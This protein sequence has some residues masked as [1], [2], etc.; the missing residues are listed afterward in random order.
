MLVTSDH[1]ISFHGGDNRRAPTET[2]LAELAFTPLFIKFPGETEGKVVEKHVTI[3]D[4]LPTVADGIGIKVPWSIEGRSAL[5]DS[6]PSD[7]VRVVNVI[8]PYDEALAQRD[9]DLAKQIDLFGTGPFD[10]AFFGLGPYEG[11]LGK[12]LPTLDTAPGKAGAATVDKAGSRLVRDFPEGGR[13][14]PSPLEATLADVSEGADLALAVNGT[15]A[16]RAQAY[17][18][19]T[20]RG[21]RVVPRPR[22]CVRGRR[23]RGAG[24]Q[25]ERPGLDADAAG[26]RDLADRNLGA[27]EQLFAQAVQA[28]AHAAVQAERARLQDEAADQLGVDAARRLDLAAR[29]VLDRASRSSPPRRRRARPRSS[30]RPR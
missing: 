4:I 14:V 23:E 22:G 13:F 17:Q 3:A 2:N 20:G 11:L 26:D 18:D 7:T 16:A 25:G 5:G 1:G 6:E 8:E 29:R 12:E 15:I 9:A 30:A 27:R 24:V 10:A 21:P 28:A 19:E